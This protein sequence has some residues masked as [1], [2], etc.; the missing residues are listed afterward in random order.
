MLLFSTSCTENSTESSSKRIFRYN[1]PNSIT[2]L[3]PAFARSQNNIWGIHHLY[4]GLVQL[5]DQLEIQ[6]CLAKSWNIGENG[7]IY[8]FILRDDV[9]FHDDPAFS[10]G[11]GRKMTSADVVFSFNRLLDPEVNSPGSWIFNGKVR[12]E[13]P[14]QA[15][16]DTTFV[17]HLREVFPPMLSILSM[18]YCSVVP[19]EAV[20]KYGDQ[21]RVHP[22]GTGPFYLKNWIENQSLILLANERYFDSG[23][24]KLDGIL[25][26]FIS[27][28]KTAYLEL[29]KNNIDYISGLE[30]S[31]VNDLLTPQ[32]ELQPQH[33]E[34]LQFIKNPFLNMEY[35]GVNV[36]FGDESNPLRKKEVRQALNYAIDRQKM[37]A[38]LRNNVGKAA[39]AGFIPRGLPSYDPAIVKG[40]DFQP[41]KARQLLMEA[42]YNDNNRMPE[43]I[44]STNKDYLDLCT[45][46]AGQWQEIG[47]R[48]KIEVM[49]SGTLR[50][51]M[52][53]GQL[54][55]FRASW[56][57]D[58]PD[59]ESFLSVFYGENPAPPNYTRF[60]NKEFDELYKKALKETN[61]RQRRALYQAMD[62]IVVE[63]A[64]VIFLFYDETA[65]FANK[66]VKG[67][68]GNA[69]N[70]LDLN[71]VV[72]READKE[73]Q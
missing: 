49:E 42:G 39:D 54:P 5:D 14:F 31:Y 47:V 45:F 46:V 34:S 70:L 4:N 25:V 62:K 33:E 69:L 41:D 29:L 73:E 44:I 68:N 1:Q 2:S 53:E 58:Y 60:Q 13:E 61:E 9:F 3:D 22:V 16:N 65:V 23:I 19:K 12:A 55:M 63:E 26:Q 71:K 8:T 43:I 51:M 15:P 64:P 32:G 6:A 57:A 37:L 17:L 10:G 28:R 27:E 35:L 20:E 18:Q 21:F 72:I 48:T 52:S 11:K 56:I 50:Q 67:L 66:S 30:S 7:L 38:S 59:G 36:Q 24:P 40:Y